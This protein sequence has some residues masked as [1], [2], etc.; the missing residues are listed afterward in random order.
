MLLY[1]GERS[2]P[3]AAPVFVALY[4]RLLEESDVWHVILG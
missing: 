4:D 2:L 1:E 3:Q